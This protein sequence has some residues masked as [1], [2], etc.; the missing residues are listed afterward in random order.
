[1]AA[2]GEKVKPV[3]LSG[4]SGTRLWP[5]SR[6]TFPKQF[7]AL[8]GDTSMFWQT[9]ERIDVPEL[10][11][12]PLVVCNEDHR[13][14]TADHLMRFR[15]QRNIEMAAHLLVEPTARNTAP[16]VAAAAAFA[17]QGGEDPLLLILP[18]DHVIRD[19]AGFGAAVGAAALLARDGHIVTFGMT[20]SRPETGYGYIKL[21]EA[22]GDVRGGYRVA[23]FT[24]KPDAATAEEFL[25]DGSYLWNG[26]IFLARASIFA[27]EIAAHAPEVAEAA[28]RAVESG[29]ADLDFIRLDLA[30][31]EA[32]PSISIDYAVM[33]RTSK[34]AVVK[35]SLGWSDIGNFYELW[36][37]GE[38]DGAGNVVIGDAIAHDSKNCY[39]RSEGTLVATCGVEDL[40]IIATADAILVARSDKTGDVKA[41]VERLREKNRREGT[42][43]TRVMRPWGSYESVDEGARYKVKRITVLPGAKLSLQKH[44]H[45]AEHWVVVN[46]TALVTKDQEKVL[47]S[48]N[49]S[50]YIPLGA[51]HRLENPGKLPLNLI[52]VQSGSYLEEDDIV[53]LEDVYGR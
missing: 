5:L 39:V 53:R 33:E 10:F 47:L 29:K 8:D 19:V 11:S 1:M 14:L 27:A 40:T 15:R 32:A 6:Q 31:F 45:R 17:M 51:V 36:A 46:G 44:H 30:A 23:R 16:A 38:K 43:H 41:I 22:I 52:E 42:E 4:G 2:L 21:G 49:Q 24:E 26:G 12:N 3:I 25:A 20:P 48:E 37:Q 50:T 7:L 34:A 18:A 28:T 13:F 9:L 35:C